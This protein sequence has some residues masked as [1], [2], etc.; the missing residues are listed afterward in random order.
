MGTV[1]AWN[2][3]LSY[4]DSTGQYGYFVYINAENE[5]ILGEQLVK[6]G[7]VVLHESYK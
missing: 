5:E 7:A 6:N 2:I 1:L 3:N 4:V